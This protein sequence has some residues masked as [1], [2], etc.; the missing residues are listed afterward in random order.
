MLYRG[1]C[2]CGNI[3]IEVEGDLT[4]A[5]SCNCSI[6]TKKGAL[7]WAVPHRELRVTAGEEPGRYLFHNRVIAHRFC[8]ACGMNPYAED[9]NE[10][11]ERTAYINIRCLEAV[12]LTAVPVMEFDGRNAL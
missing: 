7:L 12:D 6:C 8:T 10:G 5:V 3:A 9:A 2:H 1:G 11:G 4:M